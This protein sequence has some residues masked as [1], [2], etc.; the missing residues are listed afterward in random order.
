VL[1]S[2]LA[3]GRQSIARMNLVFCMA[4]LYKRF[5]DAGYRTPKFL[6]P[7]RGKTTIEHVVS[8]MVHS[9]GARDS[10]G[11]GVFSRV[12]FIANQRDQQWAPHLERILERLGIPSEHIA[13]IGD[14]QGQA[15]TALHGLDFLARLGA[16]DSQPVL[17]QPVLF[18]NI[19]TILIGRDCRAIAETLGTP[20]ADGYIDCIESDQPQYSYV[21]AD[22]HGNAQEIAEKIVISRHATTGL[23]GF[24]T[25]AIYQRFAKELV[26]G[27]E[28]FI[29]DVYRAMLR[30]GNRVRINLPS[31]SAAHETIIVGTPTEYEALATPHEVHD[32]RAGI[33]ATRLA[34][35]ASDA[36][37]HA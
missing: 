32:A 15:E 6:L 12:V 11:A 26:A 13:W 16:A 21:K 10:R 8:E 3:S 28:L 29:S 34:S 2:G 25:G 1:A 35:G 4:G 24:A 18:H 23:Y 27:K 5:R 9:P 14:T 7:F 20:E 31:R 22:A 30:A 36:R 19:D 17:C 37:R 33:V